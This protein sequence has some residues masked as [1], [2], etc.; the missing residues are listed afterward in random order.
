MSLEVN[1]NAGLEIAP[2]LGNF[3]EVPIEDDTS[4]DLEKNAVEVNLD[5][6]S[7]ATLPIPVALRND[8]LDSYEKVRKSSKM[9]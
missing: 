3:K 6:E 8:F 4:E 5:T 1:G 9:M 7:S 2:P